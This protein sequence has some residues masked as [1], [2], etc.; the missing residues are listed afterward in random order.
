MC[1]DLLCPVLTLIRTRPWRKMVEENKT[2][3]KN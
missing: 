2:P 3:E 1:D